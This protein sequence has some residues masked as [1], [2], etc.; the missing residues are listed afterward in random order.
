MKSSRLAFLLVCIASMI[1]QSV[2]ADGPPRNKPRRV[3]PGTEYASPALDAYGRGYAFIERATRFDQDAAAAE[4]EPSRTAATEGAS[5]AY[6]DALAAFSE[7]VHLDARMY[8][9]HTYIGYANRKLGRHDQALEAYRAALRLKPDYARAIEYQGEAFLGLDRFADAIFNYQRL[10][11][12]ET[13]QAKK[14]LAAMRKWL[15]ER[16]ANPGSISPEELTQAA[17]WLNDQAHTTVE[18]VAEHDTPW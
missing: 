4:N 3:E 2:L 15:Q 7:A 11:A 9:A 6:E 8:E 5:Q 13:G 17:E 10:Y 16:Q 1:A 12:L 14:L 18:A